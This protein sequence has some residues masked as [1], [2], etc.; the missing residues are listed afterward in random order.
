MLEE[1]S[2]L[3]V[4]MCNVFLFVIPLVIFE[5]DHNQAFMSWLFQ[6]IHTLFVSLLF[7]KFVHW[8]TI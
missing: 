7:L 4:L 6:T 2:E 1:L 8:Y 5:T 3:Y